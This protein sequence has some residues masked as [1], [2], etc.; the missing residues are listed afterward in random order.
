MKPT[1]IT[2]Y[3]WIAIAVVALLLGILIM[4]PEKGRY[5]I[6]NN[7]IKFDT[8]TGRIWGL[9]NGEWKELGVPSAKTTPTPAAKPIPAP[10]TDEE[11]MRATLPPGFV[12]DQPAPVAKPTPDR[13]RERVAE[14]YGPI[15]T[16]RP[17]QFGE[18]GYRKFQEE[19]LKRLGT[20]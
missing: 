2:K 5:Q 12:M 6:T 3:T 13:E 14:Q 8:A 16:P 15:P 10:M 18:P 19:A 9:G 11:L 1:D 20:R 4:L 17:P 7:A